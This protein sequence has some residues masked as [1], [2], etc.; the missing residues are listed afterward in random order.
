MTD[1]AHIEQIIE[2]IKARR[3]SW[4]LSNRPKNSRTLMRLGIDSGLVFDE[5]AQRLSY[6]DYVRGPESDDHQPP[7]PGAVWVFGLVISDVVCYLKFQDRPTGV[8]MWI[9]IHQAEQPLYFPY[10]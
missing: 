8:V 2:D 4:Q 3:N 7:I 10:R 9:S 5:I 6:R 1:I